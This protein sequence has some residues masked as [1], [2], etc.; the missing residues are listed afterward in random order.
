MNSETSQ[1]SIKKAVKDALKGI[2]GFS[3]LLWRQLRTSDSHPERRNLHENKKV[4]WPSCELSKECYLSVVAYHQT[5]GKKMAVATA[6]LRAS[7]D[8]R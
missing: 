7:V 6:K 4:M 1:A 5:Q 3:A 8:T 2:P